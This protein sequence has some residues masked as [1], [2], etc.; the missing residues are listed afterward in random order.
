MNLGSAGFR[1][2]RTRKADYSSPAFPLQYELPQLKTLPQCSASAS[3]QALY[4]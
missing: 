3:M 1:H 2:R 4:Q